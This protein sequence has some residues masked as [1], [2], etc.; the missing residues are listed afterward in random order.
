MHDFNTILV[1]KVAA[2]WE[3]IA[4]ALDYEISAVDQISS[5]HNENPTKCCRELFKD[6][7][8]TSNGVKPKIWQTLLDKLKE[9]QDLDAVTEETI[10]ELIQKDSQD[11]T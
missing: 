3:N 8:V 4:Y 5:K 7:L 1:P 9:L 6:W 10:K 11:Y 2:H